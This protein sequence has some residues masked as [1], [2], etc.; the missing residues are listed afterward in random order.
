M[1]GILLT[2]ENFFDSTIARA[3]LLLRVK[4]L[5]YHLLIQSQIIATMG[6]LATLL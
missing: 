6:I 4:R 2:R 1:E 5:H 3:M